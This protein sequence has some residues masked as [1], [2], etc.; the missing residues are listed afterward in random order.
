[1]GGGRR[2]H[3]D[4]L[5]ARVARIVIKLRSWPVETPECIAVVRST[6]Q[7]KHCSARRCVYIGRI[8]L[9]NRTGAF[10]SH[11]ITIRTA[12]P[13]VERMQ[14]ASDSAA[15]AAAAAVDTIIVV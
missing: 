13:D 8:C 12:S 2:T 1:M 10:F 7:S 6:G 9:H 14:H 4:M 5:A 11:V 3:V 15:A